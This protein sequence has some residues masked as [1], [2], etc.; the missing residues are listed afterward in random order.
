MWTRRAFLS[1]PY[2]FVLLNLAAISGLVGFLRGSERAAW[3]AWWAEVD[4]AG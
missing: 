4:A 1:I 3:K 2:A